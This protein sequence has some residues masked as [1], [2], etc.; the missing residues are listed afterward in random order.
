MQY[1]TEDFDYICAVHDYILCS[2]FWTIGL[3]PYWIVYIVWMIP[4][5][6]IW[7]QTQSEQSWYE[8]L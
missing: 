4:Y 1:F 5:F 8:E 6:A 3:S 2:S 7:S